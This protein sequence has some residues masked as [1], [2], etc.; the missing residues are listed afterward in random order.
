MSSIDRAANVT[1]MCKADEFFGTIDFLDRQ[2][3]PRTQVPDFADYFT[4]WKASARV[5]RELLHG[6]LDLAYGAA[7]SEK[8]DF[9]AA[10]E[11]DTPLLVFIHGGYWRA[12]DK[13]DFSWIAPAYAA[14][15]VSVAVLNYGLAPGTPIPEI[16]EQ[17]RRA[18]VWLYQNAPSLG[19]DR[20]R[21]ACSGHSAGGHLTG[22]MLGTDWTR[23]APQLPAHLFAAAVAISGVFDLG[24][25]TQAEFLRHDLRLDV[26]SARAISPAFLPLR[27]DVALL[28][29]V[30]ADESAEFHRQSKLLAEHWPSVCTSD[31]MD[32]SGCNHLSV[33]EAFATKG[34]PLF[35]ATLA[36]LA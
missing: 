6:R 32:V 13:A 17:V 25:L 27:N 18:S 33:C 10:D 30:G 34:N 36:L 24:P 14:A 20:R 3:N 31:L 35:E 4:R 2:Y 29:A 8:L 19:V 1:S 12:L 11:A 21:I 26:A 28:R 7:P 5:S 15:G 16:V 9:F 22:M 23:V